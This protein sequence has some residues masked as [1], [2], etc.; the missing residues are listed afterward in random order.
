MTPSKSWLSIKAT[1]P[2][3]ELTSA[4]TRSSWWNTAQRLSILNLGV[5]ISLMAQ[6]LP[7]AEPS[8]DDAAE[9]VEQLKQLNDQT[10]IVSHVWLDTE[11]DQFKHGAEEATWTLGAVWGWRVSDQQEAGI[12]LKVPFLYDRSNES[13]G[14][15]DIGGVGDVEVAAGT[16]FRLSKGWRTGGGIELHTDTASN[17]ALGDN[18]WRLHSSWSVAYDV[19]NWL[20][21]TPTADYSHSIA[22]EDGVAP[23]SYLELSLPTTLILPHDWSI[24]ANYKAKIDFENGDRWTHTVDVGVAK[25]LPNV[26]V[27]LSATLEKSLNGGTKKFQANLTMTYYFGK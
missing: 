19:T 6:V 25:R 9:A 13:S 8:S 15:M 11:W 1:E 26:P 24:G 16:A 22:E 20:T 21:L 12:R 10:I 17:P 27:V 2:Q 14:H 4:L 3:S 18:V 5:L 23:Q 7:A